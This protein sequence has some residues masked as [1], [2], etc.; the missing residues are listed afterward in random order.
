MLLRWCNPP[1]LGSFFKTSPLPGDDVT[2][3]RAGA[4]PLTGTCQASGSVG[5]GD[6]GWA[7]R[8]PSC[9][10]SL[11]SRPPAWSPETQQQGASKGQPGGGSVTQSQRPTGLQGGPYPTGGAVVSFFPFFLFFFFF[12]PLGRPQPESQDHLN[13]RG[14]R[15]GGVRSDGVYLIQQETYRFLQQPPPEPPE[16]CGHSPRLCAQPQNRGVCARSFVKEKKNKQ[17]FSM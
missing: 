4:R 10:P 5:A 1:R 3:P 7:V 12:H 16:L 2:E 14:S 11:H 13:W 8:D 6:P 15:A 9:L 17:H